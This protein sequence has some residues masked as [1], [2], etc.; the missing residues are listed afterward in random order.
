MYTP[1]R[2]RSPAAIFPVPAE[3]IARLVPLAADQ[4]G[5]GASDAQKND[6]DRWNI[7]IQTGGAIPMIGSV[8][9]ER[10]AALWSAVCFCWEGAP[11]FA[12]RERER[13]LRSLV[14]LS[15]VPG[16]YGA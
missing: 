13:F 12:R 2:F 14:L 4:L 3:E 7:P 6:A 16:S 1:S 5:W 15:D 11:P 9:I 8:T 10:R